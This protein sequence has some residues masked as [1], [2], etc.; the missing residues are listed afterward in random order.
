M[1]TPWRKISRLVLLIIFSGTIL[2]C[3][4]QSRPADKT[5]EQKVKL[6]T[7]FEDIQ[8]HALVNI[9]TPVAQSIRS[10]G[11]DFRMAARKVTAGVVHINTTWNP[12]VNQE[13]PKQYDPF[14]DF[15][16]EDWFRFFE[17]QPRGPMQGSGSGVIISPDGYIITNN[18]VIADADEIEVILHDQRSYSGKVI[19][20]D[21]KTDIALLKIEETNLSFIEFG[22]SD[23][24]EV[25]EW[26]L[27]VGNPFNLA[28]TV[29]AGIVSAKARNINILRDREAVESFIQTDAAVNPGNSGGALVN[30]D[31][32]L[33]GINSAIA[34][35]TGTYA[36]YAFAVPVNLV[37]KVANDLLNFGTV[38]RGYLGVTIRDMTGPLAKELKIEFTPGVIIDSLNQNGAA[39]K[40]GIQAKDI[41]IKVDERKI[42]TSPELQE[43]IAKHRP[44]ETVS[45]TVLRNGE[46][47]QF[48]VVLKGAEPTTRITK[49]DN[50]LIMNQ[51]GIEV[52][53]L[54]AKERSQWQLKGGVK[55]TRVIEG[56]VKQFTDIK[57]G[58]VITSLN[59][60]PIY[61]KEQFISLLQKTNDQIRI[62]G[63][64]PG[65]PGNFYYGFNI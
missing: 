14:K 53:D 49:K 54:T 10:V 21:P 59:D 2:S 17:P 39:M 24:V 18:H 44:G 4:S 63:I 11:I 22:N 56:K 55:V 38:Q 27:A 19:G 36:G 26:V 33:I 6:A 48:K 20:S 23:N 62:A 3:E 28:S 64:Y 50:E 13:I 12:T 61:T 1:K 45:V 52:E 15:F 37:K 31:G 42:E 16:G 35:P 47:K 8:R 46:E 41:I 51:L 32:K 57:K 65:L 30:L 58:F 34:T 60:K 40:A 7:N 29:T 5:S 9:D 43:V 25:G